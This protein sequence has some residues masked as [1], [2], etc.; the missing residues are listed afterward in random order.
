MDLGSQQGA[1]AWAGLNILLD[2]INSTLWSSGP[3]V[4]HSCDDCRKTVTVDNVEHVVYAAVIDR[5][6]N[7]NE[8][9]N[10]NQS[11][12]PRTSNLI[13]TCFFNI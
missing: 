1:N 3:W 9:S 13:F 2:Q 10:F 6:N 4:T 5:W 8:V 11:C 7:G 12:S